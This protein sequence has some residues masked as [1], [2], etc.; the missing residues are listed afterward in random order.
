MATPGQLVKTA[1]MALGLPLPTVRQYDRLLSAAGLRSKGGRGNS[2]ARVTA[3]DAANLLIAV[4]ASPVAGPTVK[5]AVHTCENYGRLKV[6]ARASRTDRFSVFGLPALAR[7]PRG[8][9]LRAAL[10]TLIDGV[11]HGETLKFPGIPECIDQFLGIRFDGPEPWAEIYADGS[12]GRGTQVARLVYARPPTAA[13]SHRHETKR[14]DLHQTRN[15]SF[16]TIRALGSLI[17]GMPQ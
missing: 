9:S 12:I 15:I 4:V 1:A 14:S 2:A 13:A 10:C 3:L 8:H 6:L 5:E 16:I 7:L 11:G 17:A